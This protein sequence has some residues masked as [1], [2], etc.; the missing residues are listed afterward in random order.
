MNKKLA[1]LPDLRSE[2]AVKSYY[3]QELQKQLFTKRM[4]LGGGVT[5]GVF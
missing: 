3:A 1:V 5:A 4:V 2:G